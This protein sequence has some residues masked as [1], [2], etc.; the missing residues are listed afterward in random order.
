MKALKMIVL[1]FIILLG[2]GNKYADVEGELSGSKIIASWEELSAD[3]ISAYDGKIRLNIHVKDFDVVRKCLRLNDVY[4]YDSEVVD[5]E[6]FLTF[7]GLIGGCY[8]CY[9]G[10]KYGLDRDE[11]YVPSLLFPNP[12]DKGCQTACLWSLPGCLIMFAS[13]LRNGER[14]KV[15]EMPGLIKEDTVCVDSVHLLKQKI[16]IIVE[17]SDFQKTYYTDENGNIELKFNEIVP[18][19]T[20]ADSVFNIIIQYKEM[21]YTVEFKCLEG[22]LR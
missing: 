12:S 7:L 4:G 14:S 21:A 20:E 2:C 11:D 6:S 8:G 17:K 18:E 22:L 9:S 15:K 10:Y 16:K 3:V 13:G 19:P 1:F 5:G